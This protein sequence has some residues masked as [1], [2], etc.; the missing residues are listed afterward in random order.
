MN[1][2]GQ[3][4]LP[5]SGLPSQSILSAGS[6]N[7]DNAPDPIPNVENVQTPD[8][9]VSASPS[10]MTL[11]VGAGGSSSPTITIS[12]VYDFTGDVTLSVSSAA[13]ISASISP[14]KVTLGDTQT[15]GLSVFVPANTPAGNYSVTVTGTCGSLS[16]SATFTVSVSDFSLSVSP[17]D[18]TVSAGSSQSATVS[19]NAIN[20][21][22]SSVSL[23]AS[24]LP[25]GTSVSFSP[26]PVSV[27]STASFSA[28]TNTPAGTYYITIVGT[29][30]SLTRTTTLSLTVVDF[31]LSASPATVTLPVGGSGTATVTVTGISGF[32]GVVSLSASGQ[33]SGVTASFVPA[34]V[35][36]TGTSTLTFTASQ[37][38]T[39][40]SYPIT[41]SGTYGGTTLTT[42]MTLNVTDFTLAASPA[43]FSLSPGGSKTTAISLTP[44]YGFTGSAALSVTG[45]PPGMTA[46]FAP[47]SV[48]AGSPSTLTVSAD[49]TVAQSTYSLT[50]SGVANGVTRTTT[51]TVKVSAPTV[52]V[53]IGQLNSPSIG[54][55]N[56]VYAGVPCT[57][58]ATAS[59]DP[60]PGGY[61]ASQLVAT[62]SYDTAYIDYSLTG[63]DDD[64]DDAAD[65]STAAVSLN[66]AATDPAGT[67]NGLFN[68]TGFYEACIGATVSF[69]NPTTGEDFGPYTGYG[70]ASTGSPTGNA[71]TL[72]SP[73]LRSASVPASAPAGIPPTT[74]EPTV[75][76][77]PH[78]ITLRINNTDDTNDDK[79]VRL[80][81]SH[82]AQQFTI[83]AT[84]LNANPDA[85]NVI[86]KSADG[87][88]GFS[89]QQ[90]PNVYYLS[91]PLTIQGHSSV[92]FNIFGRKIS[93]NI[94]DAEIDITDSTGKTTYT[95]EN[96]TVF[97]FTNPQMTITIGSAY[98][99]MQIGN[100][101]AYIANPTDAVTL[102]AQ[103]TVVPNGINFKAA[104]IQNLRVGIIQCGSNRSDTVLYS[105]PQITWASGVTSGTANIYTAE[106][107][108]DNPF[109]TTAN[110]AQSPIDEPFYQRTPYVDKAGNSH[111]TGLVPITSATTVSTGADNPNSQYSTT[112]S[113]PYSDVPGTV[114]YT[115]SQ[116]S[117]KMSFEDWC[118]VY[119]STL[120]Q[121]PT[122]LRYEWLCES[123]WAVN[124]GSDLG[125]TNMATLGS[126][127]NSTTFTDTPILTGDTCNILSK[128]AGEAGLGVAGIVPLRQIIYPRTR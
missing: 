31:S 72:N 26:S 20:G 88:V 16:H 10:S 103:V 105:N 74:N 34:S 69:H 60:L 14:L 125:Q 32:R 59:V 117:L 118:T 36:A 62:W 116:A 104:Q 95:K 121:T 15:A 47:A 65:G 85:I 106:G 44:L 43:S 101:T 24:G 79:Y 4:V 83:P 48:S 51:V 89:T 100:K 56:V 28:G 11:L 99:F 113:V 75:E 6:A 29:C 66:G 49:T 120:P 98:D 54:Q 13:A 110:D 87:K 52:T 80:E 68:T 73:K 39:P 21:F 114:N 22:S 128:K 115:I 42:S 55:M 27:S 23:T 93:S 58:T 77:Q 112:I 41:L 45:M 30:G 119:D 78:T 25:T 67:F 1:A 127:Q 53:T 63:A 124:I 92:N 61:S 50:V 7:T 18:L 57:G 86:V 8:F 90:A 123:S 107:G 91:L 33:P 94:K 64:W 3:A 46:G 122:D 71:A 102:S 76:V 5:S 96:M 40:G 97:G 38:A 109:T 19:I 17:S 35:Q 70:F 37:S 82:P 111:G 2:P 84:I 12:P 126:S 9:T 108:S 81:S